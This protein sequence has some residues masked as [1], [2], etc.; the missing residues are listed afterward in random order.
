LSLGLFTSGGD[1]LH[2]GGVGR[3]AEGRD[4]FAAAGRP[5]IAVGALETSAA[6]SRTPTSTGRNHEAR[7]S[8]RNRVRD[9]AVE[10]SV[11]P[12]LIKVD[13]WSCKNRSY[14]GQEY[15][16]NGALHL[17]ERLVILR[18]GT[19]TQRVG[20]KKIRKLGRGG[21]LYTNDPLRLARE[22]SLRIGKAQ[23]TVMSR[24]E[25]PA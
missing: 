18:F 20:V 24:S 23:F 10:G 6:F 19:Q 4:T 15:G 7:E 9:E 13:S 2:V 14:E 12:E 17:V 5:I 1:I 22:A 11:G 3:G 25:W 21:A 16:E 8:T